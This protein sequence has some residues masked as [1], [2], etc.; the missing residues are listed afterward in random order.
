[1]NALDQTPSRALDL[2]ISKNEDTRKQSKETTARHVSWSA[3]GQSNSG[4][5]AVRQ[6]GSLHMER[7]FFVILS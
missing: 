4:A 7:A 2:C 1:V 5:R 3:P 6:P